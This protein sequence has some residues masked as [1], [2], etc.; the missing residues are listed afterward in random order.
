METYGKVIKITVL[1][2]D[3]YN[4]KR[5]QKSYTWLRLDNMILTDPDLWGM[6]AEQKF[7]WIG[8]LAECS[9]K[10]LD[11]IDLNLEWLND[12][13]KVAI[14]SIYELIGFLSVKHIKVHDNIRPN[15]AAPESVTDE[16]RQNSTPTDETDGR[17][18]VTDETDDDEGNDN[19]RSE[20]SPEDFVQAWQDHAGTLAH[21]YALTDDRRKV[22]IERLQDASL[23]EWIIV[24]KKASENSFLTGGGE[25]G[26]V[27]DLDWILSD[28]AIRCKILEDKYRA[29]KSKRS[30]PKLNMGAIMGSQVQ[31][32][33]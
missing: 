10:N 11:T 5:D 26:W 2:W 1:N 33:S 21:E 25:K 6:T 9:K 12:Q 14:E 20:P 3:K 17:T 29:F 4:P 28:P 16:S 32:V 27:A 18:N 22:I 30:K 7:V 24:F 31:G 19:V 23:E 8:I 13:T 15:R